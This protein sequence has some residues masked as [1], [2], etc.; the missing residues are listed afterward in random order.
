VRIGRDVRTVDIH[1]SSFARRALPN[2][3]AGQNARP[4]RR[5]ARA[6]RAMSQIS[7][8]VSRFATCLVLM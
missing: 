4:F 8:S 1:D 5:S 3:M 6:A 2:G 7:T